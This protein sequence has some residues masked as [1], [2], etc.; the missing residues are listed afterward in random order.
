MEKLSKHILEEEKHDLPYLESKLSQEDSE[1]MAKSFGR[2]KMFLPT[3]S[4][5]S[6]PSKPPFESVAGLMAAPIDMLSDLFRK[7][8]EDKSSRGSGTGKSRGI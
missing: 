1:A 4:H 6:A 2:T 3:R 8:P 5:P 7:F